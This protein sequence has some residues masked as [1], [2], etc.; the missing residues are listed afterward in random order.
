MQKI[1]NNFI[2]SKDWEIVVYNGSALIFIPWVLVYCLT[3]VALFDE[4]AF[5]LFVTTVSLVLANKN[6]V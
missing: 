3:D 4:R 5:L 2:Y 6:S 1:Y